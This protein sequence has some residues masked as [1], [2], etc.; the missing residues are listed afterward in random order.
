[1]ET[2]AGSLSLEAMFRMGQGLPDDR[3]TAILAGQDN[4]VP[5]FI[6]QTV[7]SER[8]RTRQASAGMQ[9]QQQMAQQLPSKKQELLSQFTNYGGIAA[10]APASVANLAGGGIVAFS[11]END[12]DQLVRQPSRGLNE[13]YRNKERSLLPETTGGEGMSIGDI[14]SASVDKLGQWDA[15]LKR[16]F[17]PR[18]SAATE[19][20]I[21]VPAPQE[22]RKA[23]P[24]PSRA[25][26]LADQTTPPAASAQA[27]QAPGGVAGLRA[28]AAPVDVNRFFPA[29]GA[30]PTMAPFARTNPYESDR[31]KSALEYIAEQQTANQAMGVSDTPQ[32]EL[33]K[34]LL[35]KQAN[36][37][38]DKNR[39]DAENIIGLGALIL[40]AGGKNAFQ[41][42][43]LSSSKA[44]KQYQSDMDKFKKA[45]D[46]RNKALN[47]IAVA[48]NEIKRG[49][50]TTGMARQQAGLKDVRAADLT[51]A[52][53]ENRYNASAAQLA[54]QNYST[55]TAA[56]T[57]R[58][59]AAAN[60]SISQQEI[61]AR[62][63]A[64]QIAA[65][66]SGGRTTVEREVYEQ[67][68]KDGMSAKD[69]YELMMGLKK[70]LTGVEA[71]LQ[72]AGIGGAGGNPPPGAVRER[73]K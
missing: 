21:R 56:E 29:I 7:L 67:L 48:D 58:G 42:I 39:I 27:A 49:Y 50:V 20:P 63:R 52:D 6:A 43:G 64:A 45:Q 9:A 46:D 8:Q 71:L 30:A 5:Q 62:I 65:A 3:L 69:A 72:N 19:T 61:A 1:M 41:N 2:T 13:V 70:P 24:V 32:A 47:E 22:Y 26:F 53:M 15:G 40:G 12:N 73:T 14:I 25:S 68:R 44:L 23:E 66:A 35:A 10:A 18:P 54:G 16:Y 28:A 4:A 11:G 38:K 36:E 34:S 31:N 57:A 59:T 33:K 17:S 37:E 51:I 60:F 55:R